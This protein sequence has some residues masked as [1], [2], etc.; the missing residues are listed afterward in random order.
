MRQTISF[1]I[2]LRYTNFM[3]I[4]LAWLA[5]ISSG[6]EP[7][8][9]KASSKNLIKSPWL[10]N[11]FWI[12][13]ALP[14]IIPFALL[15][16]GGLPVSWGPFLLLGI[17]HAL[18]LTLYT[19]ALYKIDASTM[20]PLF[21]LRTI[22]A[23]LLS[24]WVLHEQFTV[25][26]LVLIGI[27]LLASPLASYDEHLRFKAFN[28]RYTFLAVFSMA[29]LALAGYFTNQAYQQ[30]G[31]ATTILWQDAC[32]LLFLLPT[33]AF[34]KWNNE[35][36]SVRKFMPFA[37]LALMGFTYTATTTVAYGRAYGIATV[38]VSLPLSMI[39][40]YFAAK[41]WPDMLEK[42]PGKVYAMR[43]SGAAIMVGC[44]IALSVL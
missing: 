22:F 1:D 31:A 25:L 23:L 2:L 5:S 9:L 36:W 44:A 19:S 16:G 30:N 24:V 39:F 35:K 43:F 13:A 15:R 27:I 10:F 40:V 32:T 38:I 4:L 6:I 12:G 7:V 34:V 14:L 37:F 11:V 33:L 21:S 41:K 42:H 17:S 3:D 29:A 18:F 28:N 8:I 26:K 20:A